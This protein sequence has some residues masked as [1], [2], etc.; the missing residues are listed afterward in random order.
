MSYV[1]CARHPREQNLA[2]IQV[3]G[4]IYY[5]VCRELGPGSELLVWYDTECYVLFMGIPI[6]MRDIMTSSS[7]A[8]GSVPDS[9][10]KR[11]TNVSD[12]CESKLSD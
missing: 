5:E 4:Q 3:D 7:C 6:S 12:D 1:N 2:A 11:T 10:V 9:D 8:V